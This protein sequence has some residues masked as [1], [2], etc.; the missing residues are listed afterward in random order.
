[1]TYR[2]LADGVMVAHFAFVLF[3]VFGG[4]LALR[5][6]WMAI[7]HI[8][9]L[10]WGALIEFMGW[11][12]PLTPVENRFRRLGGEAGYEG[13]FIDH[14]IGSVLYPGDLGREIQIGLGM[15]LLVFNALVYWRV[16]VRWSRQRGR[17]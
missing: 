11:P 16:Y 1:M 3:V 9:A 2:I 14:Y 15:A 6:R 5:W 7:L 12:C 4:L 10:I 8:P 13:G 17:A